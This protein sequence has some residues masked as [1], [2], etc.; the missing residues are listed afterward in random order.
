M[1]IVGVCAGWCQGTPWEPRSGRKFRQVRA[2]AS[3]G[4]PAAAAVPLKGCAKGGR[5]LEQPIGHG[6]TTTHMCIRSP[7]LDV[8]PPPPPLLL[9]PCSL[10]FRSR[11]CKGWRPVLWVVSFCMGF[12]RRLCV[13][14]ERLEMR[15]GVRGVRS[16][17]HTTTAVVSSSIIITSKPRLDRSIDHPHRVA[18][19]HDRRSTLH[20]TVCPFCSI[21]QSNCIGL[22]K[23]RSGKDQSIDRVRRGRC[24]E[25]RVCRVHQ[26]H[27]RL[28]RGT[29]RSKARG[30]SL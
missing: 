10:W 20:T 4:Q 14:S 26:H 23:A 9:P 1:G 13:V 5:G 21:D 2:A 30:G 25:M 16:S 12:V 7:Y 8:L 19:S 29:R 27:P 18:T 22:P 6:G 11:P 17:A 15:G 3:G 28:D 24:F